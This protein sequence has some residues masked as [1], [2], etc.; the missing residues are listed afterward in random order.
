MTAPSRESAV[1]TPAG[2]RTTYAIVG[3]LSGT[4]G[5]IAGWTAF[6]GVDRIRF[7]WGHTTRDHRWAGWLHK[8]ERR[9][10]A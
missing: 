2:S 5:A 3:I 4:A 10:A 8:L 9:A 1:T 6:Y 7:L